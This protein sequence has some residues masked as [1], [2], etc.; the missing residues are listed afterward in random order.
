[1]KLDKYLNEGKIIVN[2][3]NFAKETQRLI[4]LLNLAIDGND[5]NRISKLFPDI[6][7]DVYQNGFANGYEEGY[8]DSK[9]D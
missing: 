6:I 7:N 9:E 5:I 1:M 2:I 3:K 4:S 8:Q